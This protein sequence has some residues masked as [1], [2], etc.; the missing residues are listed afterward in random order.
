MIKQK[1]KYEVAPDDTK[2]QYKHGKPTALDSA[3]KRY[4]Y[5]GEKVLDFWRDGGAWVFKVMA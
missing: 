4:A 1:H 3:L 5:L 2:R